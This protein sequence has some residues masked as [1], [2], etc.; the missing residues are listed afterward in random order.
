MNTGTLN[1][2]PVLMYTGTDPL[3][4]YSSD[5]GVA[6]LTNP[7]LDSIGSSASSNIEMPSQV[8]DT[9]PAATLPVCSEAKPDP[10]HLSTCNM[11]NDSPLAEKASAGLCQISCM[12]KNCATGSCEM[13]GDQPTCVCGRCKNGSVISIGK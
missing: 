2:P 9:T 4:N 13:R 1:N 8:S 11:M 12:A 6:P 7:A 10:S 5:L 3:L